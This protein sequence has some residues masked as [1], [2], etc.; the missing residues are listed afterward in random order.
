MPLAAAATIGAIAIGVLQLVGNDKIG[1]PATDKAIVSDM[2]APSSPALPS[3]PVA[4][5]TPASEPRS[6]A[7]GGVTRE[8]ARSAPVAA[9]AP[10]PPPSVKS[11]RKEAAAPVPA[12][13]Q[14]SVDA[15]AAS[16]NTTA[17]KDRP[18]GRA[19]RCETGAARRN[20]SR[21]TRSSAK[22]KKTPRA[23]RSPPR[24]RALPDWPPESFRQAP[25]PAAPEEA[26]RDSARADKPIAESAAPAAQ[27]PMRRMQ[28]AEAARASSPSNFAEGTADV[29]AKV[30]PKLAVPDWIALIRK[31]RDEG[32][33]DE[34]AKE[35]AAFRA[36]HPDHEDLLPPDLRAWKPAA[37]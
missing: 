5:P 10:A 34:A 22:P 29:R 37:R 2:P 32:K 4:A 12:Q 30:A 23:H 36:A 15:E 19:G 13:K 27:A 24:P 8:E 28:S 1:A 33:I 3:S 16:Q 14:S 11:L 21:P 35:L 31:L 6:A 18:G 17:D 20:R 7:S 26:T 9:P 25:A